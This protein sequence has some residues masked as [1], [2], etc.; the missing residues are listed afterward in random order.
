[1]DLARD[2][3]DNKNSFWKNIGD[4]RKTKENV[5]PLLNETDD[6]VTQYMPQSSLPRPAFR[7]SGSKNQGEGLDQG[8]C[9]LSGRGSSQGIYTHLSKMGIGML[10]LWALTGCSNRC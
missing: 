1:M 2:V 3:K 10:S 7:D 4:K 5:G 6:I 8:S 9:T